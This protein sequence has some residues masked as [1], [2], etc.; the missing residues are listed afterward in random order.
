VLQLGNGVE[1]KLPVVH[2][3]VQRDARCYRRA[4]AGPRP[5]PANSMAPMWSS[6]RPQEGGA[7]GTKAGRDFG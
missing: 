2:V 3:L 6:R 4:A 7:R 5:A 1:D